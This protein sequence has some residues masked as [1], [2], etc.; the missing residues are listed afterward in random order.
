[1][2]SKSFASI[3]ELVEFITE[4]FEAKFRSY[5]SE[6]ELV[7]DASGNPKP[8]E[9]I[10]PRL[11]FRGQ[12]AAYPTLTPSLFRGFSGIN[13]FSLRA[14][15]VLSGSDVPDVEMP[16][17][18]YQRRL[19]ALMHSSYIKS[20]ELGS[21]LA[22]RFAAFPRDIDVQSLCQHYGLATPLLDFTEEVAVAAFFATQRWVAG[23]WLPCAEGVGIIYMLDREQL[24]EALRFF[25]VGI[26][27]LPRPFAQRASALLVPP[28]LNLL[29]E[30][31]VTAFFFVQNK[32][33]NL[34]MSDRFAGGTDL[35]PHDDFANV[36][37]AHRADTFVSSHAFEAY[38]KRVP[39]TRRPEWEQHLRAVFSGLVE[40]R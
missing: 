15:I 28:W 5:G 2:S 22:E 31:Y 10:K 25:E 38:V 32:K 11:F 7:T 13:R 35:Y 37:E 21:L 12:T 33:D 29:T 8:V 20:I 27:P 40:I 36:I 6:R 14:K 16:N 4:N 23:S 34:E 30:P 26:Q 3:F 9:A 18:Y 39:E 24:P 1:M 19:D 17:P